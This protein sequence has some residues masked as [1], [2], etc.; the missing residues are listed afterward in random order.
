ADLGDGVFCP[1]GRD[2]GRLFSR[3]QRD[4]RHLLAQDGLGLE[5]I[6]EFRRV[7]GQRSHHVL[8]DLGEV[9]GLG[10]GI[11]PVVT[12]P[13]EEFGEGPLSLMARIY[14]LRRSISRPLSLRR[15]KL[16]ICWPQAPAR[17]SIT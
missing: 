2:F 7:D 9:L 15:R 8:H 1:F 10:H 14:M 12:G 6:L 13:W 5:R 3:V 16:P 4:T 11:S 17:C